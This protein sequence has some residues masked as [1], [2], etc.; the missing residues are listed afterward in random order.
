MPSNP[1]IEQRLR[2]QA[3]AKKRG[4]PLAFGQSQP[5]HR[6]ADRSPRPGGPLRGAAEDLVDLE[7]LFGEQAVALGA[8]LRSML[9]TLRKLQ[10]ARFRVFGPDG[11]DSDLADLDRQ[12]QQTFGV[13]QDGFLRTDGPTSHHAPHDPRQEGGPNGNDSR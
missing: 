1:E 7:T 5:S 11:A 8:Q 13:G 3:E 6:S 4:E 9:A 12:V 10:E 2:E